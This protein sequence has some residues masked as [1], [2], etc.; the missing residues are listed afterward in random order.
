MRMAGGGFLLVVSLVATASALAA[1]AGGSAKPSRYSAPFN[2][3]LFPRDF[4]FGAGSSSYQNEGAANIDGRGPSIWDT[5]TK[6]HPEKIVDHSTGDVAADFYHQYKTDIHL[7]KKVGLDSFR[8]SISWTRILP[9]GRGKVNDLGVKFYNNVINELLANG[10]T[11]CVTL[12]HWDLPQVLEDE[13]GGFL[14]P[15]IVDDFKDYADFCFKT[16]GDRVKT[17]VTVNEPY[18][19]IVSGYNGGSKAPGRCSKYVGNC[20]AGD[21]AT[22]PYLASHHLLLAH[23]ATVRLYRTKYQATQKGKIGITLVT[24]WFKPKSK[25][26]ADRVAANRALEFYLAWHGDPVTYGDY[27]KGMKSIVGD[28]LP[29]FS[30]A[31]SEMLKGSYDFLGMNYYTSN[32]AQHNSLS[33]STLNK[34]FT[35]D[36]QVTFSGSRNGVSVGSPTALSWLYVCPKGLYQLLIYIKLKYNNPPI[37]IHENGVAEG[38]DASKPIKEAI[39]DSIRI[40][41]HDSHLRNILQA[42]KEGVNVKGYYVWAFTDN[43]EWEHGYT[44]RFGLTYV[45]YN[46]LKRKL[47]YSAYWLKM[48]L[49]R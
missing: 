48:F 20:T 4:V 22:E 31:E 26:M 16:F 39:K 9:E 25:T 18:V 5:F 34:S 43:F 32:F 13:Y 36:M 10:V 28:R 19:F 11:P 30:K 14:S 47:K 8:F 35:S 23:A 40:R 7:M 44:F 12:F 3:T 42:I 45:D 38:N 17:W 6:H 21:S 27:P 41:Y 29:K 2:R 46:N 1:A 49:L 33:A 15:K 37:Y 24:H